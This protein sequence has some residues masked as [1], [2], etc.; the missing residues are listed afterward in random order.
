MSARLEEIDPLQPPETREQLV[1]LLKQQLKRVAFYLHQLAGA[2][3][4][5]HGYGYSSEAPPSPVRVTEKSRQAIREAFR[6]VLDEIDA[7]QI[8]ANPAWLARHDDTLQRLLSKVARDRARPRR[9]PQPPKRK[10]G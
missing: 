4:E 10:A 3:H 9:T 8:E 5:A 7:A 1:G 6:G 2:S